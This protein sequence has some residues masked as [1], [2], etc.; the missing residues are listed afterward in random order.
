[1]SKKP[2]PLDTITYINI[3]R[4]RSTDF[5]WDDLQELISRQDRPATSHKASAKKRRG[6]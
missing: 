5:I 4:T 1:M 3:N 2:N 6:E